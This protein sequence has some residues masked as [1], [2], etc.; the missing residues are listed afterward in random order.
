MLK[1]KLTHP[2]ILESLAKSGHS[3]KVLIADGNYP[4]GTKANPKA[5]R[6]YL[7]L[8][9]GKLTAI[10]VLKVLKTAIP[11]ESA[12]SMLTSE[13]ESP[14]IFDDFSSLLNVPI[15]QFP[16]SDFYE[17]AYDQNLALV[18]ATGEKR[19]YGNLILTIGVVE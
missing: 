15:Q 19:L 16:P 5:D 3:G 18:I 10:A 11:I 2:Q 7:N 8:A 12:C 14:D 17:L 4:V 13:G 9:P 6:V 1:T